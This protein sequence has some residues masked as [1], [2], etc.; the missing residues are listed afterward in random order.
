MTLN[1]KEKCYFTDL[2]KIGG[3]DRRIRGMAGFL[4]GLLS[5]TGGVKGKANPGGDGILSDAT[6]G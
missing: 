6:G 4:P 1:G 3:N 2:S 5:L